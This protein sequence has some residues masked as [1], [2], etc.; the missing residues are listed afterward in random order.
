MSTTDQLSTW[1]STIEHSE[2]GK[3]KINLSYAQWMDLIVSCS[4]ATATVVVRSLFSCI[5]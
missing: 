1:L 3:S 2:N 5:E 4:R